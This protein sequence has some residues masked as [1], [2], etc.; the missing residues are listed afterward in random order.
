MGPEGESMD[1]RPTEPPTR[2]LDEKNETALA[3]AWNTYEAGEFERAGR[4]VE[5]LMR[6]TK[7]HPEVRLLQ[8]VLGLEAGQPAQALAD[9]D[10]CAGATADRPLLAFYRGLALFDLARFE[11]AEAA[12]QEAGVTVEPIL[13]YHRAQ[14]REHL[15][16]FEEA[17]EDYRLANEADP[18]EF[19]MPL[20][21]TREEF[22][23]VVV[24]AGD[25]LPDPVRERLN[26]VPVVVED[27]PPPAILAESGDGIIGP[28][29]LGLFVG[30]NLREESVFEIP[31]V[32]PAIYIYQRN[33][34]RVCRTRRE[35]IEEITTTLYHELGHYLGLDEDELR[36]RDLD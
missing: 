7:R 2:P 17:E 32:P 8:A 10:A 19:P 27:L 4:E 20:R 12:L 21:M 9:L 24:Q 34:E 11:E 13:I 6:R 16:R 3:Q 35:L 30:P 23:E 18:Q 29:L 25:R 1:T 22:R 36:E 15:G 26:E 5:R 33:L 31:G 28:D 14:V